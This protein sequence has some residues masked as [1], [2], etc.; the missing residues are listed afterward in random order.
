MSN[1]NM[2]RRAVLVS[3]TKSDQ[4][5]RISID[6]AVSDEGSAKSW[7]QREHVTNKLMTA[8]AFEKMEFD[9]KELANF[10]HYILA[11]LGAFLKRNEN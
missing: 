3:V 4:G 5:L 2:S 11:R 9:E 1:A 8:E 10:G 6:D 7:M